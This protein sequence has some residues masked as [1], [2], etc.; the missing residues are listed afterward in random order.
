MMGAM[1][2]ALG[3]RQVLKLAASLPLCAT[4]SDGEAGVAP[5]L[6]NSSKWNVPADIAAEQYRE[7][8]SFF[9]RQTAQIASSRK[10]GTRD[11]LRR[12]IGAVDQ[13]ESPRA[14]RVP[15]GAD[16][17]CTAE[18]VSWQIL[19][20]GTL[21]ATGNGPASGGVHE[22]GVLLTPKGNG[23]FPVVIAIPDATESAADITGL[24]GST[25]SA[26]YACQLVRSGYV[27][28]APFFIQRRTFS[29]PWSDDRA[30]LFRLAYLSGRHI[31]GSEVQQI[32]SA[33]DFLSTLPEANRTNITVVGVGQGGL[34]ALHAAA[35]DDRISQTVVASYFDAREQAY[36]EPE[37][38]MLW[39]H[40]LNFGD[41][42]IATLVAPRKLTIVCNEGQ[43][44]LDRVRTEVLRATKHEHIEVL[45][46]RTISQAL[47]ADRPAT[48]TP[49]AIRLDPF[50][51]A[52]IANQQFTEWQARFRNCAIEC[53]RTRE[54]WPV[55]TESVDRYQRSIQPRLENY[56]NA[57]GRYPQPSGPLAAQSALLYD[58]P[59]FLGYRLKVR[60]YDGLHV[61]GIL[62]IPK[63]IRDGQKRPLIFTVHG[64]QDRP[65]DVVHRDRLYHSFAARLAQRG[66]A[67]FAP[68]IS[69]QDGLERTTLVRRS[70]VLGRTPVGLEVVK[71]GR[72]LDYLST[73][74]FVDPERFAIYG[75]SYG[76][77]TALRIGAA[78][79]RFRAVISAGDFN[80]T[81]IKN[82][83][84]TEGTSFMFHW[85][86]LDRYI[87]GWLNE[88]S[89]SVLAR[90]IAPRA[91]MTE[92]G[93]SDPVIIEPRRFLDAEIATY[94][95]IY[96]RLG[97]SDRTGVA[98]FPGPHEINGVETFEF[99]D[100]VLGWKP[101]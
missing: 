51:I 44:R 34:T 58:E 33:I 23:P 26:A 62:L 63:S 20:L 9:E 100:H 59:A 80:E 6:P 94:T 93:D 81:T 78:E 66:Y 96:R 24:T 90:L 22:Q 15:I 54:Q 73:L 60:V 29:Q 52:A 101:V 67:V 99:L 76:G 84:L 13:L 30:W 49:S 68:M 11:D 85:N 87:F 97:L 79:Q 21:A 70:Q 91:Y 56:R 77:Y 48:D 89:D 25:A 27:V 69:V 35:L 37:D 46:Y 5:T 98:R 86:G 39:G 43:E 7:L 28:F 47:G 82:S 53:Y 50:K 19:K 31:I 1:Q 14:R 36:K 8:H 72:A 45:A 75:L 64:F 55:D 38:R 3:R 4:S 10:S 83:D 74:P 92:M 16:A 32:T 12:M 2:V 41:A 95:D 18:L 42:Q 17:A 40:L 88:F 61:C 71:F 57:L 65:E